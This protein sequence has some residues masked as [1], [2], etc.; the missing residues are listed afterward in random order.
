VHPR[1]TKGREEQAAAADHKGR[2]ELRAAE[3]LYVSLFHFAQFLAP[4][5]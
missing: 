2:E 5:G 4:L 1:T 3:G